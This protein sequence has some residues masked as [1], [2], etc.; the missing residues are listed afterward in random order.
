MKHGDIVVRRIGNRMGI[1]VG[2]KDFM[3]DNGSGWISVLW[4]DGITEMI[5]VQDYERICRVLR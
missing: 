4:G 3:P 2:F 1:I 5:H